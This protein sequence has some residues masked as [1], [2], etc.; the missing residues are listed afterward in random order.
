VLTVPGHIQA[1]DVVVHDAVDHPPIQWTV[2][3]IMAHSSNIGTIMLERKLGNA[4]LE[5][6]LRAFGIGSKTGVGLPGES[7]GI[8]APSKDWTA[9]HAANVPIGQGVSITTL[10][11]ASIYQTIANGGVRIPP[12]LVE[13]V[14]APD[15]T[16]TDEKPAPATRVISAA[17]AAKM[18]YMLQAVLSRHGTAPGAAVPGYLVAGKTGTAQRA[19]PSC[20]C[21]TGGGYD[22]TFVG[23][24]PADSPRFVVAVNLVRPT[25]SAEGGEVAAPVFSDIMKSALTQGG[26][27][28][29]GAQPPTFHLTPSN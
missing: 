10:Q 12:R 24:A 2:T 29:S 3:G 20:G 26:V 13:S 5:K 15:G 21:Y 19:N 27:V 11:M 16:V 28:P 14:T 4:T 17:T 6:Y 23:Y 7:A 8:L 9:S 25:S 18:T 1:G 22:T